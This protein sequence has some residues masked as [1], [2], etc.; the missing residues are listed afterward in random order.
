MN[1]W[2]VQKKLYFFWP[3]FH[4]E[5]F[6]HPTSNQRLVSIFKGFTIS[7]QWS[8]NVCLVFFW[9]HTKQSVNM[10]F[11]KALWKI[12]ASTGCQAQ[13]CVFALLKCHAEYLHPMLQ[14]TAVLSSVVAAAV[15]FLLSGCR[16]T[17]RPAE[18]CARHQHLQVQCVKSGPM[19][20][21]FIS[22]KA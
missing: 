4:D 11:Q 3:I 18:T 1:T 12:I 2:L 14:Q 13:V 9:R 7:T 10:F 20:Q 6:R 5:Q 21:F 22:V 17:H 19:L 8:Q 15:R 16:R